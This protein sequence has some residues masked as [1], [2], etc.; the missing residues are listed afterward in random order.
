MHSPIV[1][2]HVPLTQKSEHS[3]SAEH[4]RRRQEPPLQSKFGSA[5]VALHDIGTQRLVASHSRLAPQS[6]VVAH[7]TTQPFVVL[8]QLH[9]GSS[10][11]YWA[12]CALHSVSVVHAGSGISHGPH[13]ANWP[14]TKHCSNA[15]SQS[16]AEWQPV[17]PPAPPVAPAAPEPPVAPAPPEPLLPDDPDDSLPQ[18]TT[19]NSAQTVGVLMRRAYRNVLDRSIGT[20]ESRGARQRPTEIETPHLSTMFKVLSTLLVV[21]GDFSVSAHP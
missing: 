4:E 13:P 17:F 9:S 16:S 1:G 7:P 18:A 12:P 6:A 19:S 20:F 10:Q 14:G 5:H 2:Q 8:S 15:G 3:P 21:C 11:M